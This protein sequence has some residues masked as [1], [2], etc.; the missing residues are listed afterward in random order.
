MTET[1][2]PA[3]I[4]PFELRPGQRDWR[5]HWSADDVWSIL[6]AARDGDAQRIRDLLVKDSTLVDADYWYTP[7]LHL[8][9]REGH[10]DV[11]KVLI[12]AGA[13][14]TH[15]SLDGSETLAD[16]ARDRS[17]SSVA[18]Y[19]E[20]LNPR[21]FASDR[22]IHDA[23]KS[24]NLDTAR[25]LL[26]ESAQLADAPGSL[27][28][29]PLHYAVE[30][31]DAKLVRLLLDHGAT[32][33]TQGFSSDDR[34]GGHGFRPVAL[35]LWHHP[36]WRQRNCYE[37]ARL[38][39]NNGAHYSLPIAAAFGDED[40]VQE[41]LVGA[42]VTPNYE[43]PGGKRAISAAAERN[44]LQVVRMLL[45]H[46]AQPNLPEG[47]N[48]PR[49]YALWSA[50]RFGHMEM[51]K[52]LLEHGAD[53]NA[54]V[55]SSGS[56]TESAKDTPMRNLLYRYGG[57]V[58]LAAHYH[59]QNLDVIAALLDRC[60]EKFSE[61]DIVDGFTAAVSN[62][63]EDL[64]RLLLSREMRLP[65]H[66]TGCQTYLWRSLRLAELLL[67]NGMDPNLPNWQLMRPLHHMA[68]TGN[69]DAAKLFLEF[70]AD[71]TLVDEEYRSTPLGWA[72]RKGQF[73]FAKFLLDHDP[74]LR[75]Q[76]PPHE[77]SWAA[78]IA[79]ASRRGHREIV[80]LLNG[81]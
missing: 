27:G 7:P 51:A 32:V 28:R 29:T 46:G 80:D 70:G 65:T 75:D 64:V 66:V 35:A 45:D 3:L 43:E 12:E 81:A 56:P 76:H 50:A 8:A 17:H 4:R 78:P 67:Q 52:L 6:S 49:G 63:D 37:I 15:R 19:L 68:A 77:P 14:T 79:W 47:P 69:T 30:T 71:P 25:E 9:V 26:K 16:F 23:I 10:L 39:I 2:E 72:A 42:S 55:E 62:D 44:H 24:G 61:T 41:L 40:R 57:R 18:N 36:Y 53:P 60:P 20:Q 33:D 31:E 74:S 48:C 11:V 21:M 58:G 59:Q 54:P 1:K 34:L 22:P 38:L 13:D 73:E 5:G